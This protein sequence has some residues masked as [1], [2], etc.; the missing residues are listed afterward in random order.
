VRVLYR[1]RQ[2]WHTISLKNDP[3]ELEQAKASLRAQQLDLFLQLQPAEQSH[4]LVMY[5][6]LLEQGENQ[7]DLL[8]AALLHDVGKLRYHM[9]PIER[10][11]VVLIKTLM[12]GKAQHWGS[13]PPNGWYGM[14]AWRKAFIVVEHHAE[15]GAEMAREAGVSPLTESL[16]RKHHVPSCEETE[17]AENSLLRKLWLVDNES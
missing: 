13:L 5:H 15:W 11:L 4:A 6:K 9:Y 16:I 2:F 8:V 7:P 12:P 14:P 17:I 1:V 3:H 10:A